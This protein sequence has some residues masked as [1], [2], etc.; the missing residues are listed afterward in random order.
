MNYAISDAALPLFEHDV[1]T[2]QQVASVK[3][4]YGKSVYD[5]FIAANPFVRRCFPNF[6]PLRHRDIYPEIATSRA[7]RW[8]EALLRTGPVQIL[9]RFSRFVLGRY[10]S[11]KVNA[12]SD[13]QL[14][15]CR[16]KLHLNSHKQAVLDSVSHNLARREKKVGYS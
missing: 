4:I 14:D 8:L 2:A 12:A 11:G 15:R 9:E 13:V 10:L 7:K 6:N 3:P 1:F 5:R 16:L